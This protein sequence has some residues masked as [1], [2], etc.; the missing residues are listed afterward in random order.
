MSDA[1]ARPAPLQELLDAVA[2]LDARAT[3]ADPEVQAELARVGARLRALRMPRAL[4]P[5][6]DHPVVRHLDWALGSTRGDAAAVAAALGRIAEHLP[7][8]Y[9]YPWR[10]DAPEL[11]GRI[12]FAELVGPEAPLETDL[13]CLG[14]TLIAP[15]TLYP[16][17]RHP[18]IELYRVLSGTATWS[19]N[20]VARAV[21]P[22][23]LVLHASGV[24][25]AMRTQEEPLLALYTWTGEDVRTPSAY[26]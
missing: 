8:R 23:A 20:G 11:A 9:G 1:R 22:G 25:H 14:L 4:P 18:A 15:R 13:L 5:G 2:A 24:V 6:S 26:A 10:E 12:A 16:E 7:W 19:A 21:P 3:P 17:H